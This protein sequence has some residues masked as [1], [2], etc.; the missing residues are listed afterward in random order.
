MRFSELP[1][2]INARVDWG[3]WGRVAGCEKWALL[4][5]ICNILLP[6]QAG[7]LNPGVKL[8]IDL[9]GFQSYIKSINGAG[10]RARV[11]LD[12]GFN[13]RS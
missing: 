2:P 13:L 12:F 6:G 4:E 11:V 10:K 9:V 3:V 7:F 1:Y 5:I 8:G